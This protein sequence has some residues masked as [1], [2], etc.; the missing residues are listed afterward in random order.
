MHSNH[1][2]NLKRIGCLW[3]WRIWI[4]LDSWFPHSFHCSRFFALFDICHHW[5]LS[6]SRLQ[7]YRQWRVGH[8]KISILKRTWTIFLTVWPNLSAFFAI[9]TFNGVVLCFLYSK[10]DKYLRRSQQW[11]ITGHQVAPIRLA[12]VPQPQTVLMNGQT[13]RVVSNG[14]QQVVTTTNN[15][16]MVVVQPS[17]TVRINQPPSYQVVI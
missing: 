17:Q 10:L 13:M 1:L 15:P 9:S 12:T 7:S 6:L 16:N 11:P 2:S 14:N 4:L 8:I 3:L 5:W